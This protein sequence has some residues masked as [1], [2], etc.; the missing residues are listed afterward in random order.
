M[1]KQNDS[2]HRNISYE[3][4]EVS[5]KEMPN[6]TSPES[7]DFTIDFFQTCWPIIGNEVWKSV[8]EYRQSLYILK[9]LE[10]TFLTLLPKK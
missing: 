5:I 7:Y 4:V 8:E 1:P 2:L 6:S 10:T 9:A 3:E